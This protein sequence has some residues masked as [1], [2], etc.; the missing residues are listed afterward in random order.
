LAPVARRRLDLGIRDQGS[1][2][3]EAMSPGRVAGKRYTDAALALV[4]G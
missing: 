3:R 4:D 1:G 2:I